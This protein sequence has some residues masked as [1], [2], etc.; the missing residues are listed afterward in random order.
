MKLSGPLEVLV[1]E[2]R[3]FGLETEFGR[4]RLA[5][6][7]SACWPYWPS[8][9]LHSA[10]VPVISSPSEIPILPHALSNPFR[11]ERHFRQK[12]KH[13]LH[14]FPQ[15][16]CPCH[17]VCSN[18]NGCTGLGLQLLGERARSARAAERTSKN[19][20]YQRAQ[21]IPTNGKPARI[22]VVNPA[23]T[24]RRYYRLFF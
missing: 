22:V 21:P 18:S 6:H 23:K 17:Y 16:H 1:N 4:H 24:L 14:C 7:V 10:A 12:P 8:L 9:V 15:H 2:M 3:M 5:L 13:V 19:V 20:D 11:H